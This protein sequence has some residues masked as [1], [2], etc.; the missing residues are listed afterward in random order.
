MVRHEPCQ[1]VGIRWPQSYREA[2]LLLLVARW[3]FEQGNDSA[4]A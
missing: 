3:A 1:G 4:R 2:W